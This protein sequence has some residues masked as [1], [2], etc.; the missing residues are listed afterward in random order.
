MA[1]DAEPDSTEVEVRAEQ[2]TTNLW[3]AL[4]GGI[5][6]DAER[7]QLIVNWALR[8][9]CAWCFIGHGAWG[10]ITKAGWLKFFAIFHIPE[11]VAWKAMPIIGS[12]DIAMGLI[13][14]FRPCRAV[15]LWMAGWA[16]FTAVLRPLA[17]LS[18]YEV[19]ERAGNFGPPLVYL[20][21]AT[22]SRR[23]YGWFDRLGTL[24]LDHRKAQQLST[25]L[26]IFT[27]MLLI[28]HGGFG[29]HLVKQ[30]LVGHW[31]LVALAPSVITATNI[32]RL[33]GAF[34]I[35]LGVVTLL[36]PT[37]GLMT[38]VIGWKVFNELLYPM[39][40]QGIFEFVERAGDFFAPMAWIYLDHWKRVTGQGQ[41]ILELTAR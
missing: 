10:I 3:D 15:L 38:F 27:S 12:F 31:E 11:S 21:W 28:G 32:V 2:R 24:Q 7:Y 29:A 26:L 1:Q 19:L 5:P 41:R 6:S 16:L 20:L 37:A 14:L 34:Q 17:G 25:L 33:V 8:M 23:G 18:Y 13:I 40:G 22:A 4:A 9:A 35:A 36:A 30:R 39:S